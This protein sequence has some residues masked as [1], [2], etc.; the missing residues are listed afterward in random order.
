MGEPSL[1]VPLPA[2][3]PIKI[4]LPAKVP[5]RQRAEGGALALPGAA[6]DFLIWCET[7][8]YLQPSKR[9]EAGRLATARGRRGL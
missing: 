6:A 8:L 2:Q 7:K 5:L 4:Y 1:L 9:T 3:L